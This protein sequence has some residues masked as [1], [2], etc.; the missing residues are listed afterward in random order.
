MSKGQ[1]FTESKRWEHK[2]KEQNISLST[3]PGG[4]PSGRVVKFTRSAS[5]ARGSPVQ[6]PGLDLHTACQAMLTDV[7][8]RK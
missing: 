8:H 3:T 4:R 5:V 7:P 1:G 6:I 2:S